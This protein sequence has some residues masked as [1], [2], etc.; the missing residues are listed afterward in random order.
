MFGKRLGKELLSYLKRLWP[1]IVALEV[2]SG[3]ACLVIL[4][5]RNPVEATGSITFFMFFAFAAAGYMIAVFVYVYASM[6]KAF[7]AC[8]QERPQDLI[9]TLSAKFVAFLIFLAFSG[10]L[11]LADVSMF[12]WKAVGQMFAAFGQ[13]WYLVIQFFIYAVATA[14]TLFI[15]PA[16]WMAIKSF[17]KQN[18]KTLTRAHVGGGFALFFSMMSVVC[19][20]VLLVHDSSTDWAF[21]LGMFILALLIIIPVDV[22]LYVKLRRTLNTA[23]NKEQTENTDESD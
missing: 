17:D 2:M 5:D 4:L 1:F 19:E 21:V 7:R 15:I 18:K 22:W 13:N 20:V 8:S 12:A 3:L 16:A 9:T 6:N 14:F 23:N 11:L 10:L